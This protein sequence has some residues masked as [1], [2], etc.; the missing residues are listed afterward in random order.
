M[1]PVPVQRDRPAANAPRST[2]RILKQTS[3][4]ASGSCS[5]SILISMQRLAAPAGHTKH[6]PG[7]YL[8]LIYVVYAQGHHL[9]CPRQPNFLADLSRVPG[10]GLACLS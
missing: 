5:F 3:M 10:P 7:L 8:P 6:R 1:P 4:P 2:I 9:R